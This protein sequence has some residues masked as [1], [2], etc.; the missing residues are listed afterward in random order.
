MLTMK[1]LGFRAPSF[2]WIMAE[3]SVAIIGASL[4]TLAPLWRRN[5]LSASEDRLSHVRKMPSKGFDRIHDQDKLDNTPLENRPL[6]H[7]A[8]DDPGLYVYAERVVLK[9]LPVEG[10]RIEKTFGAERV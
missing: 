10:I 4:P 9:D 7:L 5:L 6:R 8:G 3:N 2:F 1:L